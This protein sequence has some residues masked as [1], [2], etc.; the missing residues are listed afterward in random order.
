MEIKATFE[1]DDRDMLNWYWFK[2]GLTYEEIDKVNQIASNLALQEATT[3]GAT[4]P[5]LQQRKS[6]ICWLP[7][8]DPQTHWL[9]DKLIYFTSEANKNMWDFDLTHINE[10]IQYTQYLGGGGHFNYHLDVGQGVTSR[11]KVSIVVQL[12]EPEEYEGGDFQIL[13]GREP[14]TLPRDKG[15]V[16]LFPSYLLHR[17]TPV[18][19]G[20]RRSLVLWVGGKHYR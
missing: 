17:V 2:G 1:Q 18:T 12:S 6:Q 10:S 9:Y 5:N 20:T 15:A 8:E 14:Q 19:S 11:R 16:I 4:G 3:Y 7:Q 13:T